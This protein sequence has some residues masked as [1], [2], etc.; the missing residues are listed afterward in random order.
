MTIA[1]TRKKY[2]ELWLGDRYIS[3][4]ESVIECG[5]SASADA[6]SIAES[7][8][9]YEVR[10]GA[11][12]WYEVSIR[13][14][15]D[16][17]IDSLTIVP[18]NPPPNNNPP[19]WD[20]QPSVLFSDGVAASFDM[21][22]IASDADGDQII[23]SLNTGVVSLPAGVT[24][25]SSVQADGTNYLDGGDVADYDFGAS[26]DF[27]MELRVKNPGVGGLVGLF[28]KK[29]GVNAGYVILLN[30]ATQDLT[31]EI[32]DTSANLVSTAFV[33][34]IVSNDRWHHI[35]ISVDR[36]ADQARVYVDKVEISGSPIDI[37]SVTGTL[38]NAANIR[39][40]ADEALNIFDGQIDEVRLWDDVRTVTEFAD[41]SDIEL[42]GTEAGLIGYW[43]MNG[44]LLASVSTVTDDSPNSHNVTDTGGGDLK[45]SA[46]GRL[47]YDG[48]STLTT[49]TG[50]IAKLDDSIDTTDS[51]SFAISASPAFP[52]VSFLLQAKRDY[53]LVAEPGPEMRAA[54]ARCHQGIYGTFPNGPWD[55]NPPT[56]GNISRQA[57]YDE[58]FTANSE[59]YLFEYTITMELSRISGV[60][61]DLVDWLYDTQGFD[62]QPPGWISHVGERTPPSIGSSVNDHWGRKG[63]GTQKSTFGSGDIINT[64]ITD[65][66]KVDGSGRRYPQ[67]Y[68]DWIID[69]IF[70][71]TT[72]AGGGPGTLGVWVDVMDIMAKTSSINW[73]GDGSAE[74]AQDDWNNDGTDGH[75]EAIKWRQG[76]ADFLTRLRAA[77]P[78]MNVTCNM[79]V[80]N[81]IDGLTPYV[82]TDM[83]V[84]PHSNNRSE[85]DGILQ[86]GLLEGLTSTNFPKSRVF[87]DGTINPINS[88]SWQEFYNMYVHAM[89]FTE[90][91]NLTTCLINFDV[92]DSQGNT[93]VSDPQDGSQW[94]VARWGMATIALHDGYCTLIAAGVGGRKIVHIDETGFINE[95]TTG[96]SKG[97][98][99]HPVDAPQLVPRQG[100]NIW[101]REYDNF[102]VVVNTDI[103]G[104]AT[105][106]DI[107]LFG[108]AGKVKRFNGSQDPVTNDDSV[109]NS[110]FSLEIIDAL[111]LPKVA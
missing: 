40:F 21:N 45:Y 24:W 46:S 91:P 108:G 98:G 10:V 38:A 56:G 1:Y 63:N 86:G 32:E 62:S 19:V 67:R 92:V 101:A 77:K 72:P 61:S 82:G 81:R 15:T 87:E 12:V 73:T 52:H 100:T 9:V 43:R 97:W 107:S 42:V 74:D 35:G 28:G 68:G 3:R 16:R 48:I 7:K 22:L 36:T 99:G 75:A 83:S 94:N 104:S 33:D 14:L 96:L 18:A 59:S 69:E 47:L 29:D 106:V 80:H 111:F 66:T 30:P 25:G 23:Y 37:S 71:V 4:H 65:N 27:S 70:Y 50:H 5:E 78:G 88:G 20:S 6:V 17:A 64:N 55:N 79:T 110:N 89:L 60:S 11:E 102:W 84:L 109:I 51:E 76:Q 103:Q 31:F 13:H 39:I 95:G 41:N 57:L 2:L 85:Y 26:Q 105:V 8:I 49:S 53:M 34:A 44:T 93:G 90:A 54:A 58:H